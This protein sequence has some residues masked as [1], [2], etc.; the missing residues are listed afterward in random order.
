M[1]AETSFYKGLT[2]SGALTVEFI[3]Y[4]PLTL[5][6]DVRHAEGI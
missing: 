5:G 1:R 6:Q 2:G 4:M 3:R